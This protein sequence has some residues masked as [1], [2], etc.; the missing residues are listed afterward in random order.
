MGLFALGLAG[1]LGPGVVACSAASGSFASA[2]SAADGGAVFDAG[3]PGALS[4]GSVPAT[5]SGPGLFDAGVSPPVDAGPT[6][7][8]AVNASANLFDFRLCFG[9][10]EAGVLAYPAYPDDPADPMPETNYPG[11]P[12]GGA[13]LLPPMFLPGASVVPYVVR[14]QTLNRLNEVSTNPLEATC[15][16]LVCSGG[17]CLAANADYYALPAITMPAAGGT[18]ALVVE[19]CM[20][21]FADGSVTE[22]GSSFNAASGNLSALAFA[23]APVPGSGGWNVQLAQLSP[24]FAESG[25]GSVTYVDPSMDASTP[26]SVPAFEVSAPVTFPFGDAS[27][28]SAAFSLAAPDAGAVVDLLSA[29]QFFQAPSANPFTYFTGA[30]SYFVA[31]IGDSTA[32]AAQLS[33][34]D[35][36]A[37][38]AFDGHGLHVIAYP[39]MATP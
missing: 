22:C 35:G 1:A 26:L 10:E 15:D 24:S 34:A 38:A 17:A 37:N 11:V 14:A 12:V 6:T 25:G 36:G 4:D 39:E 5:D 2:G 7:L 23:L 13:A 9:T 20:G 16:Q 3:A 33:L 27:V 29:M 28:T 21:G 18:F 19:G 30:T 32:G 31:V 8:L